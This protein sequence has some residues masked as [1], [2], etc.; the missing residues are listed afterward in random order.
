MSLDRVNF[1]FYFWFLGC[2]FYDFGLVFEK[3][4]VIF[5]IF[6]SFVKI[7]WVE[8]CVNLGL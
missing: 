7:K 6:N 8:V 1:W 3:I 5:F 2:W 4:E